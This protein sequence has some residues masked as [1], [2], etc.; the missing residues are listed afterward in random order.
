MSE[1]S[2]RNCA[3]VVGAGIGGL[4]SA[5]GLRGIG[6]DVLV[7]ERS[8]VLREVGAGISLMSNA[9]RCLDHLGVGGAVRDGG[10]TMVPGGEGVRTPSG[11]RLMSPVDGDFVDQ[12]DLTAVIVLRPQLLRILADALPPGIVQ[13]SAE[14]T[15]VIAESGLV[16]YRT[17]TASYSVE[18]DLVVGADGLNSTVRSALWPDTRPPIYS[19]HSV[20]RGM[21][22]AEFSEPGGN[23]WG[24]GQQ[25]GRMPLADG[26]VYWYAVANTPVGQ[27]HSDE[28]EQVLSRFSSWHQPIPALINATPADTVLH[29]DV[30]ELAEPLLSYVSGNVALVGDSAHAMT[31]DLGQGAC[32]ALEDAVVLCASV[33]AESDVPA[34]LA[35]YNRQRLPRTQTIAEASRRMGYMTLMERPLPLLMRNLIVRIMP[36]SVGQRRLS[37]I[38]DWNP[39]KLS[40]TVV[41][42]WNS[43]E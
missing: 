10:A 8:D 29:H 35:S 31:S 30:F 39:P 22:A 20:W 17:P 18:A 21:T 36:L 24:R 38:G 13:T 4:S 5:I 16:V 3:V 42:N 28:R 34:A 1:T 40:S 11:R 33:A 37:E 14:V 26:R 27:R 25:F 43:A 2:G 15:N 41:G 7:L 32:Q 23:T 9:R 12:H 6:W 19:G